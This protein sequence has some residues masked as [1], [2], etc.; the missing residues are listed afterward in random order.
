ML[1]RDAAIGIVRNY[2]HDIE[3]HGVRLH[4]VIL[5]GS[6]AKG[7][8]HEWS[9]IDVALVADEFTGLPED[10]YLFPYMGGIRK[11]YTFIETKTYPTKYFLEGDPFIEEISKTG[12]KII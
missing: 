3:T 2:A 5:Y 7:T 9:D 11:P 4:A 12:I 6:F 8:Q 10:H 1:T